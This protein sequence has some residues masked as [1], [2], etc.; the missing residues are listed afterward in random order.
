V[1]AKTELMA[2][3]PLSVGISP[4]IAGLE[5]ML[6]SSVTKPLAR[7]NR[8]SGEVIAELVLGVR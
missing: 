8:A 1:V 3:K 6:P 2:V 5:E 7:S 4:R